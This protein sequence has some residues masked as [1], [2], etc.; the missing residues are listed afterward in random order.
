MKY[1]Y[2]EQTLLVISQAQPFLFQTHNY[3]HEFWSFPSSKK[4]AFQYTSKQEC[5]HVW[6]AMC[7]SYFSFI[8]RQKCVTSLC[9]SVLQNLPFK[10]QLMCL[11]RWVILYIYHQ[12]ASSLFKNTLKNVDTD[13]GAHNKPWRNANLNCP[14]VSCH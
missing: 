11:G 7:C 4:C 9:W 3:Q 8:Y 13:L 6:Q 14:H 5:D 2:Y 12:T 1:W 10:L